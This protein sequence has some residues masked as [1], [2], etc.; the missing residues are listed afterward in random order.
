MQY[1]NL[2]GNCKAMPDRQPSAVATLESQLVISSRTDFC[3]PC[4]NDL[5]YQQSGMPTFTFCNSELK[6][7][8]RPKNDFPEAVAFEKLRICFL[9]HENKQSVG[10]RKKCVTPPVLPCK[11]RVTLHKKKNASNFQTNLILHFWIFF[12]LIMQRQIYSWNIYINIFLYNNIL[13]IYMKIPAT[14]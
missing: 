11:G 5:V 10:W 4:R 3:L 2:F 12:Y 14:Q 1:W 8:M 7:Q 9:M 6:F 13:Y